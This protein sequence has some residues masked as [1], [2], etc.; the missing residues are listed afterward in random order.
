MKHLKLFFAL[1]AMLALNV[2]H[3]WGAAL[4]SGYSKVTDISTLSAGDKVVIYCD[5]ESVG[6]TGF[7]TS[8]KKDATV[9][10][11]GWVEYLVE[12]ATG[13]VL[14]K[15]GDNYISLT[16]KN[17]FTYATTGSVCKVNSSGVLCCTL[18]GTDYFLY[19]NGT[20]YRMYV[21]KSSTS[22][23]KP[24][25]VYKV[26]AGGENPG[27]GGGE[28]PEEPET[29][30]DPEP[31]TSTNWVETPIGDI[32]ASDMVVVTMTNASGTY[33]MSNNNGTS[34]A[35][36]ATKVEVK[37]GKL[38]QE[39]ANEYKW[40][41]SNTSGSL[42][43]YPNGST[44][45]WLYCTAANNGV[46][47]GT[48]TASAFKI[49]AESGGYLKH[50]GTSRYLGVYNNADWR[51]YTTSTTT[52]IANQTL[53]F[54]KYLDPNAATKPSAPRLTSSQ[55]FE[56]ETFTVEIS[57]DA[58]TTI[59]YTL[60]GD[61]PTAASNQYTA[62]FTISATTTVKAIAVKDGVASSVNSATYTKVSTI[63]ATCAEAVAACTSAN[64]T[65]KYRV[66]GYVTEII[67]AYDAS[68][69]NIT[70]WMADTKNGGQVLQAYRAKEEVTGQYKDV[71]VGDKVQVVGK[72]VLYKSTPEFIEGS[73]YKIVEVAPIYNVTIK[74]DHG[75][76]TATPM[77]GIE[78]TEVT[79]TV[80]PTS[81]WV[82]DS[83]T[84]KDASNNDVDVADNKFTI[85]A[86]NVTVTANYTASEAPDAVLILMAN[87]QEHSKNTYKVGE[88][89]DLPTTIENDCS[90]VFVG[91][92]AN[93]N[94]TTEPEYAPGA[95]FELTAEEHTLYAVYAIEN[96]GT[97]NTTTISIAEYAAANSWA[98]ATQYKKIESG[99][100]TVSVTGGG[101]T[102]KYYTNG[103]NWRLYQGES[104]TITVTIPEN[105][106]LSTI[107]FTYAATN[108]GVLL[109]GNTQVKT[110]DVVS[111]SGSSATFS[112][113]NTGTATNGQVRIT[114]IEVVYNSAP[115]YSDYSTTCVGALAAPTFSV[116]EGTYDAAQSITLTADEGDIYYTLD[117]TEPTGASTK[118]T[119]AIV[120]DK[121]GSYTIKAIAISSDNE[122]PV[123]SATYQMNLPVSTGT[124]D[125]PLTT[126]EARAIYEG[127]C[128]NDEW[129]YVTGVVE[130]ADFYAS[131]NTYTITLTD[132]FQFYKFYEA[133]DNDPFETDYIK[134][135]DELVAYGQL[136]EY[137]G[138]CQ[139]VAGCY[140]VSYKQSETELTDIS[141]TEETAYTVEKAQELTDGATND[142][143]KAVYVKGIVSQIVTAYNEQYG[144][145]S[146]NIS[147]DGTTTSKQ[148][149]AYR[150]VSYNGE[151]FTSANDILVG[152]EVIIY[153][154]LDK[155]NSSYQLA[156]GNQLVSLVRTQ[157]PTPDPETPNVTPTATF[158]FNT[159][160]GL[161]NLGITYPATDA[162]SGALMTEF[163][164][165]DS[166][167]QDGITMTTTN[168]TSTVTRVW[169]AASGA[170][171]LRIYKGATLTL[172]VDEDHLITNIV[173][174]GKNINN[175]KVDN[176]A[177]DNNNNSWA[178]S[179]QSVTFD[180]AGTTNIYTIAISVAYTRNVTSG[181]YGTICLPY[182]SN[183]Y[184][185]A[186]FYDI[187]YMELEDDGT[188]P[189]QLWLDEVIGVLK[190]GKPY[191][192]RASS[193]KIT[194]AYE[195][196]AVSAPQEG[197]AGLTGTFN[198]IASGAELVGNYIIANNKF[199]LGN[200]Y[201]SLR[202][203][204]AY[205]DY[206]TIHNN[207]TPVAEIPGRRRV[208]MG[209]A[210]EN[211]ATGVDNI[212][213]PEGQAIKV[214]ENGQLIIIR[215]G[216]KFNVQGQKL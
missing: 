66:E 194:I 41:I 46:R 118:Y 126:T 216:E 37:D 142:L 107:K 161:S 144:N 55:E 170:L 120:L 29:P 18:S 24:F 113:G 52:N 67:T 59:Y 44:S 63:D 110:N 206:N 81:G 190:A 182:G 198:D 205:I 13:G 215:G 56:T 9:A 127:D 125:A 212:V 210:S 121:C 68:F 154:K 174:T 57:A 50:T 196:T 10:E 204:R 139:L 104:A 149:Q 188:T 197:V 189:K 166:F 150:G 64:S 209:A 76:V 4:G 100:V 88:S 25:Y 102:G 28:D 98:D 39:P 134:K 93:V 191:I 153:G 1:F 200:Q 143:S 20:Y 19:K 6:V 115:T 156:A 168:G 92:S 135:G 164:N 96:A 78:G 213:A 192:F 89:V 74:S 32:T 69:K 173:F 175:L 97:T 86:S 33:A 165:N 31:S 51:C 12:S 132:G 5:D 94:C 84:V 201:N 75:T 117:G 199:Y 184:K 203:N 171:D 17:T 193:S 187:A 40:N 45:T 158:I 90:K 169:Q 85:P 72:V 26:V 207:T 73:L 48:N 183:N 60:N 91:W 65:D 130:T 178:G 141:N 105:L 54:Y 103:N 47:V 133:A 49:D 108:S 79:L 163:A 152:D 43:F 111:V 211:Q 140:L 131:S 157:E 124:A 80:E 195:G 101:N 146:Y 160:D 30:V 186:K 151:K 122:S 119:T 23:Y 112:V 87:T 162:G 3:A 176:V 71:K 27:E 58:G 185:G 177:V 77:S 137:Y 136:G 14:L 82:F 145:I 53:K 61:E 38:T 128:Y 114:A 2:G 179:K 138:N 106:S 123:A 11:T 62:P 159:A 129:V 70:F 42:T 83:W 109:S 167:T 148:L 8:T 36:T 214:I 35:P 7:N 22:S 116:A 16:T 15:D 21:D 172:S 180:V 208:S 155:Y 34:K 181:N 99:D 95:E 202:A 147:T